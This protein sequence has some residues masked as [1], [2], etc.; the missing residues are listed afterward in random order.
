MV[1][2]GPFGP[3]V[4]GNIALASNPDGNVV[5]FHSMA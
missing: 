5:G 4:T 2:D 3:L 1:R